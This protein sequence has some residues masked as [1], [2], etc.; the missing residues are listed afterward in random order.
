MPADPTAGDSYQQEAAS[1]AQ[2]LFKIISVEGDTVT[3]REWTPLEPG[4]VTRKAYE[5]GVGMTLEDTVKGANIEDLLLSSSMSST[6]DL[7]QPP[8]EVSVKDP[9]GQMLA[10][11]RTGHMWVEDER[12]SS[13]PPLSTSAGAR[14]RADP[15]AGIPAGPC[16]LLVP[17]HRGDSVGP[18]P[19]GKAHLPGATS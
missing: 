2:G 15:F 4:L 3:T 11:D 14:P 18:D 12:R 10:T 19:S 1:D 9:D 7:A 16:G 17:S 13:V 5:A 6:P 8:P